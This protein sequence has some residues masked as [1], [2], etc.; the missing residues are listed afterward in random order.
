MRITEG[1]AEQLN[2]AAFLNGMIGKNY[3]VCEHLGLALKGAASDEEIREIYSENSFLKEYDTVMFA[4]YPGLE[5]GQADLSYI[6][7]NPGMRICGIVFKKNLL[8]KTGAFNTK[9]KAGLIY[10]FAARAAEQ[11]TCFVIAVEIP[12]KPAENLAEI[13]APAVAEKDASEKTA[14]ETLDAA[15]AANLTAAFLWKKYLTVFNAMPGAEAVL[16]K[17]LEFAPGL[18]KN[19]EALSADD[20]AYKRL[21]LD[22]APWFII[23]GDDTCYGTLKQFSACLAK[24]LVKCGE[25][26]VLSD[27]TYGNYTGKNMPAERPF[28]AIVGFQAK[29][30]TDDFFHHFDGKIYEFFLD[31]PIFFP[32]LFTK[33]PKKTHLLCQDGDY[34]KTIPK[35][36]GIEDGRHFPPGG[37]ALDINRGEVWGSPR[38]LDIIFM[39][40]FHMPP[41]DFKSKRER[42]FYDYM[43]A[44]PSINFEDGIKNFLESKG[45]KWDIKIPRTLYETCKEVV[46]A[47]RYKVVK[48]LLDAG[49][50]I[51]V[52]GDSWQDFPENE[53][54][55]L[56][57]HPSL[58]MADSLGVFA[59]AKLSLNVMTWHKDGMTERLANSMLNGAVVVTDET[60]YVKEHFDDE[61]MLIF[62][63]KDIDSLPDRT[64]E[65]LSDDERLSKMSKRA[66][67]IALE[68]YTWAAR[69]S[70]LLKIQNSL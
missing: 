36:Y 53:R 13:T 34:A 45:E 8:L 43:C 21:L 12:E 63:L 6:L 57:I 27:N 28:K 11:G 58:P 16:K 9:L 40:S 52:F 30:L 70:E 2:N 62:S 67:G 35:Y 17:W 15:D 54:K 60:K 19:M 18:M 49:L 59:R 32:D 47:Y 24:E 41:K 5:T 25:S 20:A 51:H 10:E 44:N 37:E 23:A 64:R 55:G 48:T 26:V 56:I 31:N 1:T 33:L 4:A 61:S 22:T 3:D 7:Q 39:G 68:N 65:L 66:R 50:T 46:A 14:A 38:D 29:A 42:D 69:T